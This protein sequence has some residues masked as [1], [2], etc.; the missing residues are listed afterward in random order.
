MKKLNGKIAVVTG[1]AMGMGKCIAGMLMGEGCKVALIDVNSETLLK[2]NEELKETGQCEAFVCDISDRQAVY[3][4]AKDINKKLGEVSI[5][6]NNAGIVNAMP[7]LEQDDAVIQKI[8]DVNL[9]SMFWTCK[10]F[11]PKMMAQKEAHV[12]NVA[13]AAGILAIPNLSVYCASKFGVIGFTDAVRQE[14]AKAKAKI[15]FSYICP[16][17]VGTGMFDGS[18]MVAGTQL[19]TAVSVAAE[20]IK[21]IKNNKPMVGVPNLPVKYITRLA[22]LLLPIKVVDFLNKHLGMWDANDTWKGKNSEKG[23]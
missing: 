15:G 4:T 8:I 21:A 11:L 3:D 14:M 23:V 16:N 13:S 22:K 19:L 9:T 5:L 18:K 17:T 10:A 20:V 12:V 2:T 7:L 6:I 1:A